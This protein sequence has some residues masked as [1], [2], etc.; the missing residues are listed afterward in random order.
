MT[1]LPAPPVPADLNL[2][3]FNWMPVDVIALRDSE[4]AAMASAE[5]FRA[6]VLLWCA[7]WQQVPAGSLPD[8]DIALARLAGFGRDVESWM[9]VKEMALHK[10]EMCSDGRLYHHKIC[11]KALEGR[12]KKARFAARRKAASDAGKRGAQRR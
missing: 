11:E 1:D 8:T 12:D 4:F 10:F 9:A 2:R 6:G 5:E 7:A 3:D